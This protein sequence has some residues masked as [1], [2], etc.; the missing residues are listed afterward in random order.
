[1]NNHNTS[2]CGK[3]KSSFLETDKHESTMIFNET[4]NYEYPPLN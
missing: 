2:E 1:M 3:I 4:D